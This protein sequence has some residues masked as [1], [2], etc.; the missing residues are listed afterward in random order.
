M[1]K[2]NIIYLV[3]PISGTRGKHSLQEMIRQK[4]QEKGITY[5]ILPTNIEGDYAF[6]LPFIQQA[7]VTD[8]IVCGGDGTVSAVAAALMGVDVRVGIIPMGSG[9]GLAFAAGIP[10]D[11]EKALEIVFAGK[12]SP[13]D[14][15]LINGQFSCMLC[16][17]GFDARVAEEFAEQPTRGLQTYIRV[18]MKNFFSARPYPFRLQIPT[19]NGHEP[20]FREEAFFISIAN[21]NQFGN[22]FTIAPR[23]SLQDGLLDIVI[24]RKTNRLRFLLS[25]VRQVLGGY[26]IQSEPEKRGKEKILYFQTA[27]LVIENPGAAPLH[28][29]GDPKASASEFHISV[30]PKAIRL[31]MP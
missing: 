1:P 28:I 27:A 25:V 13:I 9:N 5:S 4:T 30:V 2:R 26:R 24:A 7:A 17:I 12:A 11:A 3:N 10:R 16:G 21:G 14:G 8:I 19:G 23:A 22:N 31:I 18:T 15:F 20:S 6:L 29:D